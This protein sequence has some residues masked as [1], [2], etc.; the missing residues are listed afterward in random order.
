MGSGVA[1][2][3]QSR[4]FAPDVR[5]IV[6]EAGIVGPAIDF[7][8]ATDLRLVASNWAVTILQRVSQMHA[9]I[10]PVGG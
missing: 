2:I 6:R 5:E 8:V 4:Q 1:A 10:E 7:G 9:Q 3:P